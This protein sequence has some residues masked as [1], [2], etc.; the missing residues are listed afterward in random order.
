[1]VRFADGPTTEVSRRVP[2]SPEA[3]WPLVTDITLPVAGSD[4][5]QEARWVEGDR[6]APGAVFEGRNRRGDLEWTT[7]CPVTE[8]AAPHRFSW[9]ATA[10]EEVVASWGF[11]LTPA[12]GHDAAGGASEPDAGPL[13]EVRQ[14]VRLGPGR[15]GLTWAIRQRPDE[16]E[17]LIEA[18]LAQL[19]ASMSRTLALI[20]ERVASPA[21][22]G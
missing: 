20:A 16:E 21:P 13:T 17:A 12:P 5:L 19:G 2:A 7:R 10:G 3:L 9:D 6:A 15:S 11:V 8:C 14:W 4:E 1:M 22:D 18:R